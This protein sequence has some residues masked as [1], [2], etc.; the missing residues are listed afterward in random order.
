[1]AAVADRRDHPIVLQVTLED[2]APT[3]VVFLAAVIVVPSSPGP[4]RRS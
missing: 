1:V 2:L 3:F 4:A